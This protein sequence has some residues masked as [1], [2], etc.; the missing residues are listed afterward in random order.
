[1][2]QSSHDR[3]NRVISFL[4]VLRQLL[5]SRYHFYNFLERHSALLNLDGVVQV[6][7]V[8]LV[9][10]YC[11]FIN[12]IVNPEAV[13]IELGQILRKIKW[14]NFD[15]QKNWTVLYVYLVWKF[16]WVCYS[17]SMGGWNLLPAFSFIWSWKWK[18]W[19]FLKK[20]ILNMANG[21]SRNI[22]KHL[23]A[24]TRTQKRVKY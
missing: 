6:Q 15:F 22:K 18:F 19:I 17:R 11:R 3:A 1:M 10:L 20:A 7:K 21:S 5:R 8:Q 4:V 13:Y 24:L 9:Y 12:G 16:P 2:L 14:Y 23:N